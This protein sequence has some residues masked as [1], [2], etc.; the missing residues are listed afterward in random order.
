MSIARELREAL[1]DPARGEW[2]GYPWEH[3]GDAERD[4]RELL[5]E[6]ERLREAL[7]KS[8]VHSLDLALALAESDPLYAEIMRPL[9][10]RIAVA[11]EAFA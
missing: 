3:L 8:H 4:V 10:K 11:L 1:D 2:G 6:C 7:V 5:T 9:F